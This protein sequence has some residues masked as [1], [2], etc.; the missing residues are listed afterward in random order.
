VFWAF[1]YNTA[2]IPVAAGLLY[3]VFGQSGVPPGFR[4]ILGNY[5]FLNPILAAAATSVSPLTVVSNSLRL[6][7]FRPTGFED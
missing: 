1:A 6:R 5:G 4:F 2:L 3:L 7:R